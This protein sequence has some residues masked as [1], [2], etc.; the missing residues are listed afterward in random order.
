MTGIDFYIDN[1]HSVIDP[2]LEQRSVEM[3]KPLRDAMYELGEMADGTGRA[4]DPM[5]ADCAL[6]WLRQWARDGAF[7]KLGRGGTVERAVAVASASD[8]YC[9]VLRRMDV[10]AED[11]AL[12]GGW[13]VGL[14]RSLVELENSVRPGEQQNNVTFW[15]ALAVH[16]IGT[17]QHDEH[18]KRWAGEVYQRG[19]DSINADGF[20]ANEIKRGRQALRYQ[21]FALAPLVVMY[22]VSGDDDGLR[23]SDDTARLRKALAAAQASLVD[24]GPISRDAGTNVDAAGIR[25]YT[26][27]RTTAR[28]SR[29]VS[30]SFAAMNLDV[31]PDRDIARD[32]RLASAFAYPT[33]VDVA[34][35][36]DPEGRHGRAN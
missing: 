15:S 23:S 2:R 32:W 8:A 31:P 35:W 28:L 4:R 24:V 29:C 9:T 26:L 18:L 14:A 34:R 30:P 7:T 6:G 33:C 16:N 20:F 11:R 22:V 1:K 13:F 5:S 3:N 25:D 19:L 21:W 36:G 27:T 10:S 12:I 17:L